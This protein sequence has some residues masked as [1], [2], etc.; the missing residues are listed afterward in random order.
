[1]TS[2]HRWMTGATESRDQH[3]WTEINEETQADDLVMTSL[4][5]KQSAMHY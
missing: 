5:D 1:L 3:R 2:R 4:C